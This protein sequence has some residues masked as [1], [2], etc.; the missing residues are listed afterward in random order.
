M[1]T[2]IFCNMILYTHILLHL[3]LISIFS[4]CLSLIN[5]KSRI[6]RDNLAK[7]KKETEE[8]TVWQRFRKKLSI[9]CLDY[10]DRELLWIGFITCVIRW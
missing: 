10:Q 1:L 8:E 4:D 5:T 9:P 7:S 3:F 2:Y 6:E